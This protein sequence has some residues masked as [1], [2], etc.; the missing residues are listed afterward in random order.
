LDYIGK[1]LGSA[2]LAVDFRKA[3]E[4]EHL[5]QARLNRQ[6]SGNFSRSVSHNLRGLRSV[7]NKIG[8]A[9]VALTGVDIAYNGLNVS[10]GIDAVMEGLDFTGLGAQLPELIL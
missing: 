6:I 9:G 7:G 2:G 10:N 8:A 3:V 1:G 4:A 5:L